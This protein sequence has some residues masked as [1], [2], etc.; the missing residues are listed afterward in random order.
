MEDAKKKKTRASHKGAESQAPEEEQGVLYV[1]IDL[2]TSRTSI[3][4]SNGIREST[5]SVVGYPKDVVSRK[6]LRQEVLFGEESS[7]QIAKAML[8]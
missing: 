5:F 8:V 6:L 2:G 7:D 4:S 1:G 3:A